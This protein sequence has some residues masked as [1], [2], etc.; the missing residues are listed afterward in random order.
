MSCG[1][2]LKKIPCQTPPQEILTALRHCINMG[3]GEQVGV[4]HPH[5]GAQDKQC[6]KGILDTVWLES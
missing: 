5:T 6:Y 4:A 1:E 3:N 2:Q